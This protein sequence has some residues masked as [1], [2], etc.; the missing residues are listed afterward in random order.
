[1]F[2]FEKIPMQF[3]AYLEEAVL[4]RS[5]LEKL[6]QWPLEIF[7]KLGLKVQL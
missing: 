4:L 6:S 7:M 1:M 5:Y 2:F 3:E